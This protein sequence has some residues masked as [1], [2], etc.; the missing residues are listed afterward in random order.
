MNR[1]ALRRTVPGRRATNSKR[2][3]VPNREREPSST[4]TETAPVPV[5][6]VRQLSRDT[7]YHV[8]T[9]I[10]YAGGILFVL[11][12]PGLSPEE[13]ENESIA[14]AIYDHLSEFHRTHNAPWDHGPEYDSFVE[15]CNGELA[16]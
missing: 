15:F 13:R 4:R 6:T 5:P 1:N 9:D 12:S 10:D 8:Y 7:A 14:R 3:R 11:P 16:D 2:K